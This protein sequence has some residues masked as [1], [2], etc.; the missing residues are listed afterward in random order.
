M[1]LFSALWG[2]LLY[3]LP[4]QGLLVCFTLRYAHFSI[5][6]HNLCSSRVLVKNHWKSP[7]SRAAGIRGHK[8]ACWPSSMQNP[9][10][11]LPLMHG[12][13]G[14]QNHCHGSSSVAE[15]QQKSS[16]LT[17]HSITSLL[18]KIHPVIRFH[19]SLIP[20]NKTNMR[21]P[22]LNINRMQALFMC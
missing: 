5:T 3:W 4:H 11:F 14:Q 19:I 6:K 17:T 18:I 1:S 8:K 16:I 22:K 12:W 15:L 7:F 10:H 13:R 20:E 9:S 21:N 2:R